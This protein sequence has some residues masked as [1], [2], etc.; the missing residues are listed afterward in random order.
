MEIKNNLNKEEIAD[1]VSS[2]INEKLKEG[3]KVLFL[4]EVQSDW[5][6]KGKKEDGRRHVK[7]GSYRSY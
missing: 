1:Y 4:V 2:I 3:K 5:G 6:Q 7:L